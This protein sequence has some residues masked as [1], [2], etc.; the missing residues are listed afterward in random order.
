M[1]YKST[2]KNFIDYLRNPIDEKE[3]ESTFGNKVRT[4][5]YLF[6]FSL[7][8][9]YLYGILLAVLESIHWIDAGVNE[10]SS[11]VYRYTYL[12]LILLGAVVAPVTEELIFRLPLRYK[13]NY[14][15]RW[16]A[17]LVVSIKHADK[18][19]CEE[20]IKACWD[21]YFKYFFYF[22]I[23]IFGCVHFFNFSNYRNVW[24]WIIVLVFPQL[25]IGSIL[26]YIRVRF[27][28]VWSMGYHAFHNFVFFSFA[29]INLFTLANYQ[30]E[31]HD[32]SFSMSKGSYTNAGEN[33]FKVVPGKV[34]FE[35]YKLTDVLEV[36][37]KRPAKYFIKNGKGEMYVNI[38]FIN[39][40]NPSVTDTNLMIVSKNIQKAMKVKISI[41]LIL[42]D[43]WELYIVDSIK[44]NKAV[45]PLLP[46]DRHYSLRSIGEFLDRQNK[47]IYIQSTDSI[48]QFYLNPNLKWPPFEII[49]SSWKKQY[50]LGFRKVHKNL[51][52][53]NIE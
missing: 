31:N 2:V 51:E 1:N 12:K 25:I 6:L 11:I 21:K 49:K 35:N 33:S 24:S 15:F 22:I 42:K 34:I 19:T 20:K 50:G 17:I 47:D 10:N 18:A 41:K 37:L 26:G 36:V 13:Y 16:T 9:I 27:S 48:H 5:I 46:V 14:L 53:I 7:L 23:L 28:I 32:Y 44:Y 8:A 38:N 43:V 30:F 40:H 29:F 4:L 3:D 52:F 39:K 45:I